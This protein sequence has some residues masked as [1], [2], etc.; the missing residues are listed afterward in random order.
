MGDGDLAGEIVKAFVELDANCAATE[1]L[2]KEL[3]AHARKS[4]G[5]AIAPREID[6]CTRIP[7]NQP[8]KILLRLLKTGEQEPS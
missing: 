4:L 1:A 5:A 3:L 6:F 8:G 2:R 7:K